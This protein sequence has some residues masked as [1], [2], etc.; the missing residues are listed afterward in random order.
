MHRGDHVQIVDDYGKVWKIG[1][2]ARQRV[3]Q[4]R[5]LIVL[6]NEHNGRLWRILLL[7]LFL[8][9]KVEKFVGEAKFN[10]VLVVTGSRGA[11]CGLSRWVFMLNECRLESQNK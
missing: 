8:N 4:W 5:E 11:C 2:D 7:L 10:Q 3:E 1:P 9:D 6:D